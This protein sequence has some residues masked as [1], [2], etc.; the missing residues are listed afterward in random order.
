MGTVQR[1]TGIVNTYTMTPVLDPN[2][3]VGLNSVTI[4]RW[5]TDKQ[6]EHV[7]K[8]LRPVCR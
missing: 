1:E 5:I 4:Q 6:R 7:E 8:F 3:F 2:Y